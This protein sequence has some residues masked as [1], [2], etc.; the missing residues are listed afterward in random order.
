MKAREAK[1]KGQNR[2]KNIILVFI[3][4]VGYSIF[5][6]PLLKGSSP[7]QVDVWLDRGDGGVYHSSDPMTVYFKVDR[8]SYVTV[9]NI[10]TDGYVNIL[11]PYY[12][13]MD[14]YVAGGKTYSVPGGGYELA[15]Y[16]DEPV[17]MGYIEA[18]ASDDP[19]YLD[20]W[21]FLSQ[22]YESVEGAEV[23]RRITGDPFLSIDEINRK[24]LPF[25]EELV[26]SDDFAMY[27]VEEVV[28]YPRYLC[29][30]CHVPSYYHYEPYYYSCPSY[31]IV[32]YAYWYYNDY[33]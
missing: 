7:L 16:I 32:V 12:P 29:S 17:G 10:D 25:A 18:V 15:L 20:E 9:Y 26:Y 8:S 23:I 30:D 13:G 6:P 33:C 14:N 1:V 2:K 3:F 28:H 24:I 21:P 27:Y 31:Y 5:S 11:Y 22:S 19:F 4:C